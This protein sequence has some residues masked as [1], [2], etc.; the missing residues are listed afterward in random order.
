[1]DDLVG[2][3]AE[4][5]LPGVHIGVD[6]AMFGV[7]YPQFESIF[8]RV[9]GE[10]ANLVGTPGVDDDDVRKILVGTAARVYGFDLDA[11]Q[12][13]IDRV[14][15]DLGDVRANAAELTRTMQHETKAPMMRSSLARAAG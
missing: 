7:D 14:G 13:D 4:G 15:F 2:K 5:E 1:M 11:M 10:V 6:A 9:M 12:S 8:E 3:D